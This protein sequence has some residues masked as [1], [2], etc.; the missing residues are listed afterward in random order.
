M[1]VI[2]IYINI[3]DMKI[4]KAFEKLE[5][6]L[7]SLER[8]TTK[9]YYELKV[10]LPSTWIYETNDDIDVEVIVETENGVLLLLSPTNDEVTLDDMIDYINIVIDANEEIARKEEEFLK[11][12]EKVT[13]SLKAEKESFYESLEEFRKKRFNLLKEEEEKPKTSK[14]KTISKKKSEEET[15]EKETDTKDKLLDKISN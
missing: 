15:E 10:G 5:G 4:Q 14:P 7:L 6:R 9:G 2:G 8:N 12:M 11:K 1:V 13:E 3:Y